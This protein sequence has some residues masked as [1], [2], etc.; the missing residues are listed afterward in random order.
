Q[1][2][3]SAQASSNFNISGN[4]TAGGTL[5]ANIVNSNTQY[6]IGGSRVFS[7]AGSNNTFAGLSTGTTGSN[8]SFFGASAGGSNTS[9]VSNAF[10]GRSAGASNM[11]GVLN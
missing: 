4:G 2:T 1:N 10:F 7:I 3:T 5:S 11:T 6:N 8:N 9:G